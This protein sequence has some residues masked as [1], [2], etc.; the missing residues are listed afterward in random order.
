MR[1][2][3]R[4]AVAAKASHAPIAKMDENLDSPMELEDYLVLGLS[5]CFRKEKGKL[6]EAKQ[7][8]PIAPQSLECMSYGAS[9]SF[10]R[11]TAVT[12]GEAMAFAHGTKDLPD[13][14]ACGQLCEA[15]LYRAEAAARCWKRPYPEEMLM[16][17]VP[18][19]SV[20]EF[21]TFDCENNPRVLNAE[22]VVSDADNVKQ[23]LSIDVYGRK[24]A[25]E[26]K[27]EEVED[28]HVRNGAK[29]AAKASSATSSE[30][31]DILGVLE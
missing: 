12:L 28:A 9:T 31:D 17:L 2:G 27:G 8:E 7:V 11:V 23:D 18:L 19:G 25:A 1:A 16:A 3:A 6:V 29:R 30:L 24:E 22:H 14:L 4:K 13:A 15:F 10:E 20:K 26:E 5:V 21:G